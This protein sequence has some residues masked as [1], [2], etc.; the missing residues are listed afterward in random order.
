MKQIHTVG[1]AVLP[2]QTT[3]AQGKGEL[4]GQRA[5]KR[6]PLTITAAK[7][8]R[9]AQAQLAQAATASEPVDRFEHAHLA[10]LRIAGAVNDAATL[11]ARSRKQENVWQK[12]ARVAPHLAMWALI[13][14]E[15]A[16]IRVRVEAGDH[17]DLAGNRADFWL[18]QTRAFGREVEGLFEQDPLYPAI[19]AELA[20]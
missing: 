12:L 14:E 10:A 6:L 11:G 20:A 1:T 7:L 17:S 16:A 13:F 4:K 2:A 9:G 5:P 15:S 8:L 3:I 19:G 18:D